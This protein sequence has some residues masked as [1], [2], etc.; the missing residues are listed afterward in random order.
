MEFNRKV[1]NPLLVGTIEV[2]K[3]ENTPEHRNLFVGELV[4][5][6]LLVPAV[7]E[8]AP[9]LDSS[10]QLKL[11]PGSRVQFPLL[12]TPDGKRFFMAFTDMAELKK[13]REE[14]NQ[15]FFAVTFKDLAGMLF[16]KDAQGNNAGALGFVLNPFSANIAVPKEMVLQIMTSGK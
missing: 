13:W 4:K 16:G 7:V 3:E 12:S 5:A 14:E 8:P 11:A 1:S 15:P 9:A 6:Q 10:G 2:M